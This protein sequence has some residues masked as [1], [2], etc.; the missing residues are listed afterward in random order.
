MVLCCLTSSFLFNLLPLHFNSR[1]IL[2]TIAIMKEKQQNSRFEK[3]WMIRMYTMIKDKNS[4][5]GPA[6]I[7]NFIQLT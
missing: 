6:Y 7:T 5:W 3:E 4:Y 1:G 2:L